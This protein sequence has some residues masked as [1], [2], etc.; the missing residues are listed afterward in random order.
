MDDGGAGA[1]L[2]TVALLLSKELAVVSLDGE[3]ARAAGLRLDL[4][5]YAIL[6]ATI[7]MPL[8]SV[9]NV[10]VLSLLIT[11]AA[12]ARTLT[13]RLWATTL[14]ASLIGGTGALAGLYVSYAYDLAV[15]GSIVCVL[16]TMFVAVW[17]LAPRHGLPARSRQRNRETW[18]PAADQMAST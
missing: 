2:V 5:L 8:E 9:G 16:T 10:L 1:V 12:A 11:P 4:I 6:T 15:G 17:C 18:R 3:T 13:E 14:L 7:V